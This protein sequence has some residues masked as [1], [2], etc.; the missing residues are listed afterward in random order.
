MNRFNQFFKRFY[1]L[2]PLVIR[3]LVGFHLI[4]TVQGVIFTPGAMQGV[5]DFFQSQNIIVP[6]F[7]GPFVAYA[8]FI[9]GI[10]FILGIFTRIAALIMVVVF[11]CAISIVHIGDEYVNTFPALVMLAGSIFLLFC[12]P[13]KISLDK[14]LFQKINTKSHHQ[15]S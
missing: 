13:G 2:G 4:H 5:V 12:G 9:C 10:L 6:L 14:A 11:I 8:E 1:D 7:L 3:I 15:P